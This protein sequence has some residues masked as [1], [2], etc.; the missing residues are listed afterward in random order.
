VFVTTC[1]GDPVRCEDETS[2]LQWATRVDLNELSDLT[3]RHVA[4]NTSPEGWRREPGLEP[5]WMVLFD[6]LRP[7]DRPI[8]P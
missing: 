7:E 2:A 4:A 8:S 6:A 5:I 3:R 1:E